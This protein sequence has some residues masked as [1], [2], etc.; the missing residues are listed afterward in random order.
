MRTK[1]TAHV[2]GGYFR[3]GWS[4]GRQFPSFKNV[5]HLSVCAAI[6]CGHGAGFSIDWQTGRSERIHHLLD[7]LALRDYFQVVHYR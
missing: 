2:E 4:A 6:T 5:F 3:H 1:G 7:L